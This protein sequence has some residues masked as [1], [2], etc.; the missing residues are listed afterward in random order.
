MDKCNKN[1][2]KKTEATLYN[3]KNLEVKITNL[4]IDI[5]SLKNN[6]QGIA[7]I[8]YKERSQSTNKFNSVVENEV[9]NR[10]ENI[11]D[12][13]KELER[14]KNYNINLKRKIDN[15]LRT[16]PEESFKLVKLRYFNG[17][18]T[19]TAI[20]RKLNMDK[21]YCCRKRCE[22][23]ESLGKLIYNF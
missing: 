18:Q 15:A 14:D 2:F 1:L 7:P 16:L 12:L 17:K 19:W 8:S 23:I 5:E 10:E 22:I 20:G 11:G 9:I 13:I 21:D 3:Y 6:Y 4:D